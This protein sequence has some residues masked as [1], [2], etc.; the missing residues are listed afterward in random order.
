MS[1]SSEYGVSDATTQASDKRR[2]LIRRFGDDLVRLRT[3]A[4]CTA[5]SLAWFVGLVF[6]QWARFDFDFADSASYTFSDLATVGLLAAV[7]SAVIGL[8]LGLYRNRW[9]YGTLDELGHVV[10]S[11]VAVTAVLVV[12]R[13]VVNAN[14]VPRSTP[15]GGASAAIIL[16][17]AIRYGWR[18]FTD[19]RLRPDGSRAT[20]VLVIGAGEGGEQILTAM[21]RN[22]DSP[23]FPVGIL[24]DDPAK[25]RL[26]IRGVRVLGATTDLVRVAKDHDVDT[27]I[28][29]IPTASAVFLRRI[30]DVAV[31]ADLVVCKVPGVEDLLDG[32]VDLAS[33]QPITEADLLGR[34]QVDTDL[35]AIAGYLTGRRVLVTGAGGSIGSELCRQISGFAPAELIMV[36]R[37]ESA[38]H[39]V[40]LSIT[41]RALLDDESLVVADIRDREC[42][43]ELFDARRPEV[44]FHAAALKHVTLLE[45]FPAEAL[46]TN[47]VG[48]QNVLD[49]ASAAG[50]Q[51]FVNVSTD[52]AADPSSVL[53]YTKR[54]AERLTAAVA[55]VGGR[56]ESVS[57]LSVRFG[58]VLGSRGSVLTAFRAQIAAGGP[59]TVTDRDATR[60]F[61]T[62]EEAVELLIQAGAMAAAGEAMVLDMG[63]PVRID[64]VARRLVAEAAAAPGRPERVAITYTGL[65]PGEKLHEVLFGA[66][67][68]PEP[69]SHPLISR[70]DV[71]EL[72]FDDVASAAMGAGDTE[73]RRVL[74]S[75]AGASAVG[76]AD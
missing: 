10:L 59:V 48:T 38:L 1:S 44:V 12:L 64:D 2:W 34:T 72:S 32:S 35:E 17:V 7:L 36:D 74:A 51:R 14:L 16:M 65:R 25:R 20:P 68:A 55:H 41:G 37:D 76:T 43:L 73:L 67:E 6:A 54:I 24:D 53:G 56:D 3:P 69:S 13:V 5:D 49:A 63:E 26:S 9:R 58:N 50:V 4:Q 23:Y 70:V 28:V 21:L 45:R 46:K 11:V 27:V 29:A 31:R 22:P 52:K 30:A 47:V 8:A 71:P 66:D 40:Q 19:F 60:F 18:T 57:Y 61:M 33:I 42:M 15:L 39:A 75:M 62:V